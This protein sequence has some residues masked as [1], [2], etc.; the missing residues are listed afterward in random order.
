[1]TPWESE[2]YRETGRRVR[3]AR[4]AKAMRQDALAKAVGLVRT[5]IVNIEAGK[6]KVLLHTLLSME[7]VLGVEHL[8]L[9]PRGGRM[10]RDITTSARAKASALRLP[11]RCRTTGQLQMPSEKRAPHQQ[12]PTWAPRQRR[13]PHS[14][15]AS[16]L[17]RTE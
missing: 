7:R 16:R 13:M 10:E 4:Q 14:A 9:V 3:A 8:S 17:H 5:S 1:M 12:C 11:M 2:F 6:Q 15:K